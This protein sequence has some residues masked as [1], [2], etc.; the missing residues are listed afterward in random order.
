MNP[1]FNVNHGTYVTIPETSYFIQDIFLPF[2]T[3]KQFK[4]LRKVLPKSSTF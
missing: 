4:H 2:K 1:M 3:T